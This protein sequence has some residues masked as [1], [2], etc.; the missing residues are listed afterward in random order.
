MFLI[1][2]KEMRSVSS[3]TIHYSLPSA[4][5]EGVKKAKSSNTDAK[6]TREKNGG[7]VY[8]KGDTWEKTGYDPDFQ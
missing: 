2:I 7:A 5:P 8:G 4:Q 3:A 1:K 6:V